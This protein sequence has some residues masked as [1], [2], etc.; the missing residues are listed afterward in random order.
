MTA[1]QVHEPEKSDVFRVSSPLTP[2]M[3]GPSLRPKRQRMLPVEAYVEILGPFTEMAM[4][5]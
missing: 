1:R 4:E 2:N 3:G 5:N